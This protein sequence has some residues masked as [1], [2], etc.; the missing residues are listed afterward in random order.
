MS[1]YDDT[2]FT[3]LFEFDPFVLQTLFQKSIVD[4]SQL[5]S[6]VNKN[7][8]LIGLP[9][10]KSLYE[11]L[12]NPKFADVILISSDGI[13]IPSHRCIL[14]EYSEVLSKI[15]DESKEVPAKITFQDF[16]AHTINTAF[17]LCFGKHDDVNESDEMLYKFINQYAIGPLTVCFI[18]KKKMPNFCKKL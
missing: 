16:D 13:E 2:D 8:D 5:S 12:V 11:I 7:E 17:K 10:T 18:K 1:S 9:S 6:T 14:S 4:G 15:M 3:V